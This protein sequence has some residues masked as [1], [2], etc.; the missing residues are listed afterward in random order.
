MLDLLVNSH[1][2]KWKSITFNQ[3][4]LNLMLDKKCPT[5]KGTDASI[6]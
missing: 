6:A 4:I 5:L 2:V 1:P 3:F